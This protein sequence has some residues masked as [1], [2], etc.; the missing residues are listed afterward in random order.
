MI[1]PTD[2]NRPKTHE[3]AKPQLVSVSPD[4]GGPQPAYRGPSARSFPKSHISPQLRSTTYVASH[5]HNSLLCRS[6]HSSHVSKSSTA[7]ENS[8]ESASRVTVI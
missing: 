6:W 4:S 3:F 5:G 8:L 7:F 1:T 2:T